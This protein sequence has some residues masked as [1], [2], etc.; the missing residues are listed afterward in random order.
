MAERHEVKFSVPNRDLGNA[1]I[2]FKAWDRAAEEG[3]IGELRVSVG[4]I[5]WRGSRQRRTFT[6]RLNWT[7]FD[8]LLFKC[9]SRRR[10]PQRQ[11]PARRAKATRLRVRTASRKA[12]SRGRRR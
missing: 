11:A 10:R 8:D 4:G 1:D 9:A 7:E 5:E 3:F 12:P 6:Y 2:V